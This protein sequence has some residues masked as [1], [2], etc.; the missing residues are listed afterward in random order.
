MAHKIVV[1]IIDPGD[2]EIKVT[3][4]FWSKK[5]QNSREAEQTARMHY[6]HH[7]AACEYFLEAVENGMVIEEE[8]IIADDEIPEAE[9]EDE[10]PE[11]EDDAEI[12]CRKCGK[13]L[14]ECTC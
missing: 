7:L 9:E 13:D 12:L 11:D 5:G 6:T 10:L 2:G 4:T 1:D 14:D 8:F 3:H